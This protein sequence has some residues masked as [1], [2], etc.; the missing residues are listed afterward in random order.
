[1]YLMLQLDDSIPGVGLLVLFFCY[2]CVSV[3][4]GLLGKGTTTRTYLVD[5]YIENHAVVTD[6]LYAVAVQKSVR[7]H[8]AVRGTHLYYFFKDLSREDCY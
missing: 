3:N 7:L 6:K 2:S 5:L 4:T 1:M 8:P